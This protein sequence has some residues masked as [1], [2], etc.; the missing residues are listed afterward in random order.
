MRNLLR[1]YS[2]CPQKPDLKP[3]NGHEVISEVPV[4]A[5]EDNVPHHLRGWESQVK[6]TVR[7]DY[8]ESI[9]WGKAFRGLQPRGG[10]EH[11][12]LW[13]GTVRANYKRGSAFHITIG[14]G[15]VETDR[16]TMPITGFLEVLPERIC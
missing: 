2:L 16:Q 10:Q 12:K 4:Q 8:Q 7:K 5:H 6:D 11:R 1:S 15:D 13:L 3:K 14:R 9:L